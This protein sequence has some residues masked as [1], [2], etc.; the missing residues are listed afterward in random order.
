MALAERRANFAWGRPAASIS[1]VL[2]F[3][4][5]GCSSPWQSLPPATVASDQYQDMS[6]DRLRSEK[7]RLGT[8]AANL[9]PTLFPTGGEEKRKKDLAQVDG[10]IV[11]IGKV[12]AGKK[13]PGFKNGVAPGVDPARPY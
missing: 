6:C 11:A 5:A 7:A 2:G 12:Q 9:S 13:C 1:L 3:C 10:E 4:L 8:E